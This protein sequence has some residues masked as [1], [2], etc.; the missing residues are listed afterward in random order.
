[1]R[2]W[3]WITWLLIASLSLAAC[4]GPAAGST[5]VARILTGAPSTI[6]P[7]AMGDS[8]SAAVTAQLFECLTTFDADRQT[9][10]ALAESWRI[11][12]GGRRVVFHLR[13]SLTFSDGTP[14]QASDVVRSWLRIIDPTAPSPLVSLMLDVQ[15]AEAF[16][17]GQNSDPTS[18]GLRADDAAGDVTVD[19]V[20]PAAD[21]VEVV[22]SPTFGIV[23]P[24]FGRSAAQQL[25]G[26]DFVGSGGYVLSEAGTLNLHANEHYWAGPPAIATIELV[27]DT[28]GKTTVDVFEADQ[29]DYAPINAFDASWI[30]YD[31]TL[32]PQLLAV[33]SLAVDYYGFDVRQAPFDDVRVRQ[34]FG[35]AIDWRQIAELGSTAGSQDVAT[36]MVPPGIPG[37]SDRDF[38]PK[39]D[40]VAA[41]ALLAEAGYP[42][43]VGFPRVSFVTGGGS[44]DEAILA[45]LKR[46][47]GITL[48]YET[49]GDGYF[50]R[51]ATNPPAMW[52]M[53]WVADY[54]GRNDFLGILLES[55]SSNNYGHYSSPAFDKAIAAAG[56]ATDEAAATAAY[57]Q[58]ETILQQDVPVVPLSYG[59]GWALSRT[60]LLGTGQN[61]LGILRMA[62][63]A[64]AD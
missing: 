2:R 36:S 55:G 63:L 34:A 44:A 64:W 37:R 12:D 9:R 8:G 53:G 30:A 47:L 48:G 38:V 29:V 54:P 3:A 50:D 39:H 33:P 19:L 20:R 52:S 26:P 24:G 22:A 57:D 23:P 5:R 32:G 17:A 10:P 13:P 42:G 14:L 60:G 62:G 45:D 11:E 16:V 27:S 40:P 41:R 1:M 51:L 59:T 4:T 61:G 58:A 7:A 25:A 6:D 15:G 18:V 43:G 56:A 28:A 21:F 46:E 49:M 31:K 35:M